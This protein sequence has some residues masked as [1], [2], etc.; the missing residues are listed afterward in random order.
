[1]RLSDLTHVFGEGDLVVGFPFGKRLFGR[2]VAAG[3]VRFMVLWQNGIGTRRE[4]GDPK[5]HLVD[6]DELAAARTAT[7]PVA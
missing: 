3:K 4:Q 6:A 2:V 7:E 5:T 1:M